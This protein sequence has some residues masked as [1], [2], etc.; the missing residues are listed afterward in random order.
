MMKFAPKN[1]KNIEQTLGRL[2][3]FVTNT[4]SSL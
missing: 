1:Q 2:E 3:A 4:S